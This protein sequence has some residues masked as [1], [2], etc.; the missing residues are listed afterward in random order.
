MKDHIIK[1]SQEIEKDRGI[2]RIV[3]EIVHLRLIVF[4]LCIF[5]VGNLLAQEK[6]TFSVNDSSPSLNSFNKS[7]NMCPGG[8]I[9][10]IY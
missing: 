5:L 7:I 4:M 2:I 8:I 3:V 6:E 1:E 9:F 10:G